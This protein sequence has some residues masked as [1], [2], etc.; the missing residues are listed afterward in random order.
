MPPLDLS[1]Y[2]EAQDIE[3]RLAENTESQFTSYQLH[4]PLEQITSA[5]S[6]VLRISRHFPAAIL[7]YFQLILDDASYDTFASSRRIQ[8]LRDNYKKEPYLKPFMDSLLALKKFISKHEDL[9]EAYKTTIAMS[10]GAVL[11]YPGN[12]AVNAENL[13]PEIVADYMETL[14]AMTMKSLSD[15]FKKV[16]VSQPIEIQEEQLKTLAE[17]AATKPE[18]HV[19]SEIYRSLQGLGEDSEPEKSRHVA[20]A[21][22]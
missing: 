13:K 21:R 2:D 12:G 14:K 6:E 5:A 22:F 19:L 17:T 4:V 3:A 1:I 9:V 8:L 7:E 15:L 16:F 18:G 10:P 20:A 11:R